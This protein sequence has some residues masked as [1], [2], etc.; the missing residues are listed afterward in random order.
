[1][2]PFFAYSENLKYL[3]DRQNGLVLLDNAALEIT[4]LRE[5]KFPDFLDR[6]PVDGQTWRFRRS[7]H[8]V[9]RSYLSSIASN[10]SA[11]HDLPNAYAKIAKKLGIIGDRS[12][13]GT[14]R[15]RDPNDLTIEL[16][17]FFDEAAYNIF[18]PF[19][20]RDEEKIRD[21]LLAYVNGVQALYYHPSLGV[22]I[23][24]ALVRLDIMQRQPVDLRVHNG[25]RARLL[26]SFCAYA[27]DHNPPGDDDPHHWDMGLYVSGLDFW[28]VEDGSRVTMGLAPVNGSCYAPWSCVIAEL[29][30]TNRFGKPYPSAGFT[31]VYIAAHEIGHK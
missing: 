21:M 4:P 10:V 31:S 12:F 8:V 20:D 5:T 26:D 23:D 22:K 2:H 1:M 3:F 28:A 24:I 17:V 15:A 25:E 27:Q 13:A 18:S 6:P 30:V 9:K 19:L 16:A 7:P 14:E 11:P 29:G